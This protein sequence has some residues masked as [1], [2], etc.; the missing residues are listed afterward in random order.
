MPDTLNTGEQLN[1]SGA[2]ALFED[3][4]PDIRK[5]CVENIR[6]IQ[7]QHSPYQQ[8]DNDAP[9]T[10]DAIRQHVQWLQVS[11]KTQHY[12]RVITR[13][14]GRK[15][16][17]K[18]GISEEDVARAKEYLVADLYEGRLFGSK[19]KYGKCPFHAG[20]QERTPSFYIFPNNHF[21]CFGCSVHGTAID[22]VM[23][24]DKVPFIQAVKTLRGT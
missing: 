15:K 16:H 3:H 7:L 2:L 4:L 10:V 21:K 1:L 22:F 23:L 14:D 9:I 12:A 18:Q 6:D 8:L 5:A 11:D 24:R 20:G 13:I 19:R 17:Y